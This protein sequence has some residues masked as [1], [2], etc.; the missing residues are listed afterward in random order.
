MPYDE[1]CIMN[2]TG[3]RLYRRRFVWDVCV[4]GMWHTSHRE[5]HTSVYSLIGDCGA[6]SFANVKSNEYLNDFYFG[7][8]LNLLDRCSM[9]G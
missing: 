4:F 6:H 9:R 7:M 1:L 2:L 5:D 8:A 3:I